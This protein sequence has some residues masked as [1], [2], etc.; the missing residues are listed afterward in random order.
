MLK[1][2][3]YEFPFQLSS[4]HFTKSFK[5]FVEPVCRTKKGSRR[6]THFKPKIL[7]NVWK[8]STNLKSNQLKRN[9]FENISIN[10][11]VKKFNLRV[12]VPIEFLVFAIITR[13]GFFHQS[14]DL[15]II[16]NNSIYCY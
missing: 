13:N 15:F 5:S 11:N 4:D 12:S 6:L 8:N 14:C 9:I 16:K 10:F 3:I 2:L 1:N 7:N